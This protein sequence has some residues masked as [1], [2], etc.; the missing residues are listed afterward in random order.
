[1]AARNEHTLNGEGMVYD[2]S[3]EFKEHSIAEF[4]KKNKQMLGFSGKVRSLTTVVHEFVTN[5][6]DACEEAGILPEITVQLEQLPSG[7]MRLTVEDNGPGIPKKLVGKA[8]G[9]ML[10]GTKF[11]RFMQ[12]RGQQG[13]GASGVVLYSQ[14]TTGKPVY[15]KTGL[16]DGKAYEGEIKID[17]QNNRPI[18]MNEREYDENYRGLKVQAV[19][20]DVKYDKSEYSPFEYIKRTA[21]AN[22]HAQIIFIDPTGER[23]LFPRASDLVPEKPIEVQPHPLG[24]GTHDLLEYAHASQERKLSSFFVNTFS[25]FSYG[26]VEETKAELVKHMLEKNSGMLNSD[27]E[28]AVQDLFEA[29]PKELT[30]EQAEM[31]IYVFKR[32]KWISPETEALRP[33]G[34]S[35]IEKA[36]RNIFNPEYVVVTERKPKIF[37]GGI[38]FMVEAAIAYGGNAGTQKTDGGVSGTIYR[39]ANRVP[40]LFDAG[41]CA[42]TTA[43]KGLDWRRYDVHD[44]ENEPIS[45]FINFISVHVPYTGA[46][47]QAISE[48]EEIIEEVRLAVMEA[49]RG[50]QRYLHGK[51]RERTREAKKKAILRYVKQLSQDL[52]QLAG[53]GEPEQLERKLMQLVENKYSQLT[54]EEAEEEVEKN[55]NGEE[56]RDE[57]TDAEEE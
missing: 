50:I 51:I 38:P 12:Q 11:H 8:L 25:R 39:F 6:L 56:V 22:P 17:F 10:A 21:L 29:S 53:K 46:G 49:A 20:G 35:Q 36:M 41:G 7:H 42:L 28:K 37:R 23:I 13:I 16:G 26:K 19:F 31:L 4:F 24:I 3:K 14:I 32:L 40:L 27:A 52:P 33:I 30:W 15:F 47:K 54:L 55:G 5:S 48:E 18:L 34:P 43:V 2:I 45:V 57:T 1:M 9:Q 44:F